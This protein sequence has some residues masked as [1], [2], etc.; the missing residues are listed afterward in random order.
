MD[1]PQ[2]SITPAPSTAGPWRYFQPRILLPVA[3]ALMIVVVIV[4]HFMGVLFSTKKET[5]QEIAA[6]KQAQQ[7]EQTTPANPADIAGFSNQTARSANDIGKQANANNLA[8][9]MGQGLNGNPLAVPGNP[10][11]TDPRVYKAW[12]DADAT[13]H[14]VGLSNTG[15]FNTPPNST[16]ASGAATN[17]NSA[18]DEK[19]EAAKKRELQRLTASSMAIDYTKTTEQASA[20]VE[21]AKPSSSSTLSDAKNA[22]DR[23]LDQN[24]NEPKLL[25]SHTCIDLCEGDLIETVL[26]NRIDGSQAGFADVIVT[27]PVF[28]HDWDP[29]GRRLLIPVGSRVLGN[30]TSVNSNQQQRLFVAFHKLR[31]PNGSTFSLDNFTGLDM[32]GAAGLRDLVNNHYLR[33]FG[34]AG[35]IA[36]IG[37]VAQIGNNGTAF[38]Y[39][40]GVAMRNGIS[41]Q[42]GQEAMQILNRFLNQPPTM[43]V[44]EG[45]NLVK[46]Y[47]SQDLEIPE[48]A[49]AKE[50]AYA[51]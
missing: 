23:E 42:L 10:E 5:P 47:I 3:L 45:R 35:A 2:H 49:P 36:A 9:M 37:A 25:K 40:P 32:A 12:A 19:K 20:P 39:D 30:V 27:Q 17:A 31:R 43:V 29:K 7:Y 16:D 13:T 14:P 51:R 21:T 4:V 24:Q 1:A 48:Y 28:S 50:F 38:S 18:I 22:T 34:V 33:I 41:Q 46:V 26:T 11:N 8:R 6:R 15:G 44:R